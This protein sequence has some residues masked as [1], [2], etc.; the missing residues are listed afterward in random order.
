MKAGEFTNVLDW[1]GSRQLWN[2]IIWVAA[3]ADWKPGDF[4]AR[5]G[6][7]C[8]QQEFLGK[9]LGSGPDRDPT[10]KVKGVRG[11]KS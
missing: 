9:D 5:D 11:P 1:F 6:L 10:T 7:K 2:C 3:A 4:K 8:Q